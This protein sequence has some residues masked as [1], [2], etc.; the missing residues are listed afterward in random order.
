M[1]RKKASESSGPSSRRGFQVS[2][3]VRADRSAVADRLLTKG[4]GETLGQEEAAL[5]LWRG[6][7]DDHDN[8][9]DPAKEQAEEP[10]GQAV[11]LLIS[12]MYAHPHREN[13]E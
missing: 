7:Y 9:S 13:P 11:P 3:A 2:L 5:S 6:A 1:S 4:A 12:K 10:A 8:D